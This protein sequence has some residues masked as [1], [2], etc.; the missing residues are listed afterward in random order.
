ME[1]QEVSC[2]LGPILRRVSA[3]QFRVHRKVNSDGLAEYELE[4]LHSQLP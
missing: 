1:V 4:A 2:D 3:E